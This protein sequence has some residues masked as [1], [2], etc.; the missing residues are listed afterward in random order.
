MPFELI[1]AQGSEF[2]ENININLWDLHHEIEWIPAKKVKILIEYK[3]FQIV[4]TSVGSIIR[5]F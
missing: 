4:L 2:K 5:N 1:P 3:L